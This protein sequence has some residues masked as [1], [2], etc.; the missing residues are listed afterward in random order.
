MQT[1]RYLASK[2][3]LAVSHP[4]IRMSRCSFH[5]AGHGWLVNLFLPVNR[6]A[7][8]YTQ[9]DVVLFHTQLEAVAVRLSWMLGP[10]DVIQFISGEDVTPR[11]FYKQRLMKIGAELKV[12][13]RQAIHPI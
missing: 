1:W 2:A 6:A 10:H 12:S 5:S 8:I 11:Q 4:K 9:A 3:W 13:H 7:A